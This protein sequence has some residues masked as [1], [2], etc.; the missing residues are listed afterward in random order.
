MIELHYAPDSKKR[1]RTEE[2]LTL[3][4]ARKAIRCYR[5]A[6]P[7][8]TPVKYRGYRRAWEVS[9]GDT[10]VADAFQVGGPRRRK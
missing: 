1:G 4:K 7:T 3:K 9:R 5:G 2:Y 8:F 6:A 10:V